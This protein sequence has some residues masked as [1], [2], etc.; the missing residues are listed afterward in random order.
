MVPTHFLVHWRLSPDDSTFKKNGT[1]W[2]LANGWAWIE[3]P[4]DSGTF[5][6]WEYSQSSGQQVMALLE[7]YLR[8]G[9][10]LSA[11]IRGNYHPIILPN[12][13]LVS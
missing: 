2:D 4:Q 7:Q 8:I 13:F 5:R 3:L 10:F 9:F 6:E 1:T 12:Y 11:Q